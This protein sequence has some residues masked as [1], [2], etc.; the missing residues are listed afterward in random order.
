[1]KKI[2]FSFFIALLLLPFCPLF[3]QMPNWSVNENDYQYTM[4]FVAKLNIDGKQLIGANDRVGAF[5]GATCRGTSRVSYIASQN[6]HYAYLTLFSNTQNEEIYF[7]LYDSSTD[8]ITVV[9][10]KVV[11]EANTHKGN[12]FQ[13]YSI[14]EPALNNKADVISF[15][16]KDIN[17][18]ATLI[19]PNSI[20]IR[21]YENSVITN[22]NPI[23]SLSK[24]AQLFKNRVIQNS[25]ATPTDFSSTVT[26][27]VLSE[28]ESTLKTYT[29][30]VDKTARQ[31]LFYKKDVVCNT[32]GVIKVVSSQ[33]G[34]TVT[35]SANGTTVITK[36]ITNGEVVFPNLGVNSYIVTIGNEWKLVNIDLKN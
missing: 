32:Q 3:A 21:L 16:F 7:K 15:G 28:D 5:V 22:L 25:G 20:V 8:K 6:S 29:V 12:L 31:T 26:Y 27:E 13:S 2:T 19:N 35:I 14:A 34:E 11:F 18:V 4:T 10:N 36:K 23:F 9:T 1:M 17:T 30:E 24:G 33:E